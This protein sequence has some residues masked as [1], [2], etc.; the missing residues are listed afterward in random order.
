MIIT[1]VLRIADSTRHVGYFF[2]CGETNEVM[3]GKSGPRSAHWTCACA[4]LLLVFA[5]TVAHGAGP[6]KPQ[7]ANTAAKGT[8]IWS[9]EFNGPDGSMPDPDSPLCHPHDSFS[10]SGCTEGLRAEDAFPSI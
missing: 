1:V 9:D 5:V 2:I 6:A 7:G 3:R 4:L 8:L 10:R